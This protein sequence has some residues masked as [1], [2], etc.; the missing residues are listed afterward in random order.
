MR[1]IITLVL[2]T[3]C[4]I[5]QIWSHVQKISIFSMLLFFQLGISCLAN[6]NEEKTDL[7]VSLFQTTMLVNATLE[8]R[9]EVDQN[10]T[11]D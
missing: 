8:F 10:H 7:N 1:S 11:F 4:Q 3:V 2:S 9:P 6:Q 5:G